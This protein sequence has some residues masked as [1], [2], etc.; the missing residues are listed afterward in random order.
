VLQLRARWT[1]D[2]WLSDGGHRGGG[3]LHA[4]RLKDGVLFY[5]GYK[6]QGKDKRLPLGPFDPDGQRGLTLEQARD[7]TAE[8]SKVYRTGDTDI[9]GY[10]RHD[11]AQRVAARQA[12][13]E[14]A[15]RE[16]E[17]AQQGS[18]ERLLAEYASHLD[19][20]G[21]GGQMARY[22]FKHVPAA[23]QQRRAAQLGKDDFMPVLNALVEAGKGAAA[24]NLRTFLHAAY[25][26]AIASTSDPS[27]PQSL[28]SFGI[29][30]NPLAR[31]KGLQKFARALDRTLSD[32]ELADYLRHLAALPGGQD[33]HIR[34]ALT[35]SLYLG[36]QRAEQLLR[37]TWADV[38][39]SALSVTLY[40]GKGKRTQPRTHMLPL[41]AVPLHVLQRR[42]ALASYDPRVFVGAHAGT[43]SRTVTGICRSMVKAGTAR[44]RFTMRDIRRT[45]ETMLGG[46]LDVS[47]DIRAQIQ[48]HGL[49]GVQARHYDMAKYLKQKRAAL[50]LWATHLEALRQR[51][52]PDTEG[53]STE[54]ALGA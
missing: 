50:E 8:L 22:S 34:D 53:G 7:R 10:V 35:V 29:E 52:A 3:R 25:E 48:S 31:V 20:Q 54:G 5:F 47:K 46:D 19:R 16:L 42:R 41:T 13:E 27:L 21:K 30:H 37:L 51:P 33:P 4:R 11:T 49:S 43:L 45:A 2:E 32:D 38:D 36:G 9:H 1:K 15:A 39:L 12:A 18:L 24:L 17:L 26:L 44:G 23:L 14:A 40:D 28:Q 6:H